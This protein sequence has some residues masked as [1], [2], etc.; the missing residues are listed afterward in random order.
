MKKKG[1]LILPLAM[2]LIIAVALSTA[3]YAWFAVSADAK[4][5]TLAVNTSS[6]DGLQ[7]AAIFSGAAKHGTMT[8]DTNTYTWDGS[9]PDYGPELSFTTTMSSA[10]GVTGDGL[11]DNMYTAASRSVTEYETIPTDSTWWT[12]N[13]ATLTG[14]EVYYQDAKGIVLAPNGA[15]FNEAGKWQGLEGIKETTLTTGNGIVPHFFVRTINFKT[16]Q[17]TSG[18]AGSYSASDEFYSDS[19]GKTLANDG[20]YFNDGVWRGVV[21][22]NTLWGD[23]TALGSSIYVRALDGLSNPIE[24]YVEEDW[25]YEA[26]NNALDGN[27]DPVSLIK[28]N[29]NR[30]YFI[31]NFALKTKRGMV[32]TAER[33]N[34]ADIFLKKLTVTANGGMAAASRIALFSST[35]NTFTSLTSLYYYIPFAK[36]T[37]DESWSN[38]GSVEDTYMAI[39]DATA[40]GTGYAYKDT[41]E[42]SLPSSK[43]IAD[44]TEIN[45]GGSFKTATMFQIDKNTD[46]AT[47]SLYEKSIDTEDI[48]YSPSKHLRSLG[49]FTASGVSMYYTMVIWFEGTDAQCSGSFAGSGIVVDLAFDFYQRWVG[50]TY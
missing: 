33:T 47:K 43:V 39:G 19:T 30:D 31:L 21:E 3:T 28:A 46:L 38:S 15:N 41:T 25:A 4:I 9:T 17:I 36:S 2:M 35:D 14:N 6:S 23:I 49:T 45:V 29:P 8:L 34:T 22:G 1:L 48:G 16:E 10:Y 32:P 40:M 50:V 13:N 20:T 26:N 11:K 27:Q 24:V 5:S 44:E 12:N 7:I 37:Y 42:T 18:N